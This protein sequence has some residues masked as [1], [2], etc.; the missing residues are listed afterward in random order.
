MINKQH[1]VLNRLPELELN[2]LLALK[3]VKPEA[4]SVRARP[5]Q[6]A[7]RPERLR[8]HPW[9][10]QTR[11]LQSGTGKGLLIISVIGPRPLG[12]PQQERHPQ[13]APQL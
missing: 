13:A 6:R 8:W 3:E 12:I 7:R 4:H 1:L 11:S 5:P 10:F 2:Y 9:S